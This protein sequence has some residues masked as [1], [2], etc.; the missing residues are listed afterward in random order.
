[1]GGCQTCTA[2][3]LPMEPKWRDRANHVLMHLHRERLFDNFYAKGL[4]KNRIPQLG[5]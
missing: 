4:V 5:W 1:M 3:R 2:L